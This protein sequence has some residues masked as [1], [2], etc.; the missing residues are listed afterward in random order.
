MVAGTY[1]WYIA[2]SLTRRRCSMPD[3]YI[4]AVTVLQFR[5]QVSLDRHLSET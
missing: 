3:A 5:L 2:V 1:R 4:L